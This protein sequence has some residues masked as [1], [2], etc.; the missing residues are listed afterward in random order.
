M[1]VHTYLLVTYAVSRTMKHSSFL[2][3]AQ[4]TAQGF[5][6]VHGGSLWI[7]LPTCSQYSVECV[8]SGV[9]RQLIAW[10]M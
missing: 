6:V 9:P 3:S 4:A 8:V 2:A 1:S 10:M 5:I 7:F